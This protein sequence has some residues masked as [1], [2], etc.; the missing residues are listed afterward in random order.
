MEKLDTGRPAGAGAAGRRPFDSDP[1]CGHNNHMSDPDGHGAR[2][3]RVVGVR[4][5]KTRLGRYLREVRRGRVIVVTDRGE[6]VAEL[7]PVSMP[8]S[9]K[10]AALERL[11]TLGI[12]TRRSARRMTRFRPIRHRGASL[13]DAVVADRE[14]RF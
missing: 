4:E 3:R 7:R 14:D 11:V 5:L 10:D 8:A 1:R 12:V 13:S 6:P 2:G 9:G